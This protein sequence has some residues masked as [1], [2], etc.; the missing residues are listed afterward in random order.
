MYKKAQREV[1]KVARDPVSN[2]KAYD[3]LYNKLGTRKGEK[4]SGFQK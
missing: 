4:F 1:M 2:S 3:V